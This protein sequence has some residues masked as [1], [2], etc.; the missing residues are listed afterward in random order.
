[1]NSLF[2]CVVLHARDD[3]SCFFFVSFL[4]PRH[5]LPVRVLGSTYT[6]N[7]N[8]YL[9]VTRTPLSPVLRTAINGHG[10]NHHIVRRQYSGVS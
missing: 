2:I 7:P 1:M 8:A 4:S 5:V 6:Y 3:V 10:G 9:R